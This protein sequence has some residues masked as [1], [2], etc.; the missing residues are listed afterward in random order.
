MHVQAQIPAALCAIHNFIHIHKSEDD[1]E[2]EPEAEDH[3]GYYPNAGD[4]EVHDIEMIE[5]M[6][7]DDGVVQRRNAIAQAMW[8]SYLTV[9]QQRGENIDAYLNDI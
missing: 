6:G 4:D 9:L 1:E 5:N 8:N 7:E 2:L 3:I